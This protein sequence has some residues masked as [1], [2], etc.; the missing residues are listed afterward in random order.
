MM[1]LILTALLRKSLGAIR[2]PGQSGRREWLPLPTTHPR[3]LV[4]D[5][6]T[7]FNWDYYYYYYHQQGIF[8]PRSHPTLGHKQ[9]H[10]TFKSLVTGHKEPNPV[11]E[12]WLFLFIFL[13]FSFSSSTLTR[14]QVN[15]MQLSTSTLFASNNPFEEIIFSLREKYCC[16]SF[17]LSLSL[18]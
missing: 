3:P 15:S 5:T 10:S 14:Q 6:W 13:L 12:L 8:Y 17:S 7:E 9:Q 4:V 1:T 11:D 2:C 16:S 18:L